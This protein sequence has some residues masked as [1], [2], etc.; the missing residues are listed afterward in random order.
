MCFANNLSQ[1]IQLPLWLVTVDLAPLVPYI[2]DYSG[3][4]TSLGLVCFG[5][6]VASTICHPFEG[7]GGFPP[8]NSSNVVLSDR[9]CF[10]RSLSLHLQSY[11]LRRYLDPPGTH[12]SPTI[13]TKVRPEA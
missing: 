3:N 2:V 11:L 5:P 9:C 6:I 7:A 12:P 1:R 10:D 8:N 13:E 4:C